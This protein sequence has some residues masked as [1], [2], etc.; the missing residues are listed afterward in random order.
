MLKFL[1]L[2]LSSAWSKSS[3]T[4]YC[5]AV[6]MSGLFNSTWS[7]TVTLLTKA[8][9]ETLIF[10]RQN[11]SKLRQPI[12]VR[13]SRLAGTF[14]RTVR[15][16]LGIHLSKCIF[17]KWCFR[18]SKL[19]SLTAHSGQSDSRSWPGEQKNWLV[20][21]TWLTWVPSELGVGTGPR[22]VPTCL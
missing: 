1:C 8:S 13:S 4:A 6:V 2:R 10:R 5:C 15:L 16:C 12:P 11:N 17:E 9:T 18:S 21:K 7:P 20:S 3:M 19:A 14:L 22:P